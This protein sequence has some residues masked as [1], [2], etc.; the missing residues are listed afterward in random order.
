MMF[1][2]STN[3]L[4]LVTLFFMNSC[5]AFSGNVKMYPLPEKGVHVKEDKIYYNG[6]LFAELR[7]FWTHKP[8]NSHHGLAIYYYL[9][10]KELW[11][12]PKEGW[13]IKLDNKEYFSIKDLNRIEKEFKGKPMTDKGPYRLIGGTSPTKDQLIRSRVTDIKISEDGKYVYYKTD[14]ILF[15]SSHKYLLEY[16]VSE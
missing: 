4:I 1:L 2:K 9:Y 15:K 16:G 10:D 7:Y 14:G 12:V 6:K 13:S 5:S 11:I 3:L 8:T